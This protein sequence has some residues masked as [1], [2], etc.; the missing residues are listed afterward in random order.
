MCPVFPA[1]QHNHQVQSSHLICP[2]CLDFSG[3]YIINQ[4][5]V[6]A[7]AP[8]WNVPFPPTGLALSPN[9]KGRLSFYWDDC[10]ES[11]S[12][13]GS[14]YIIMTYIIPFWLFSLGEKEDVAIFKG[15]LSAFYCINQFSCWS[16]RSPLLL[17]NNTFHTNIRSELHFTL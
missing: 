1:S 2:V 14:F 16:Q 13:Q 12:S 6:L 4:R 9:Y 11:I 10:L 5:W 7:Q 15:Y 8:C 17:H 3:T